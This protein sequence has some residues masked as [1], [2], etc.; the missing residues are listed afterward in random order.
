MAS[1]PRLLFYCQHA[2][3]LG[4]LVRSWTIAAALADDFDV[5]LLSGGALPAGVPPPPRVRIIELPP[6]SSAAAASDRRDAILDAFH[7]LSP[8]VLV[9]ELFPFGRKKFAGELL[10]LLDA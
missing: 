7:A 1:R 6:N 5:A 2:L 4:H 8:E 3:G 10:P 9:I